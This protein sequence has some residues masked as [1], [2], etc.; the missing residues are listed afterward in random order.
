MA[1]KRGVLLTR[2]ASRRARRRVLAVRCDLAAIHTTPT[3]Y[4]RRLSPPLTPLS[5]GCNSRQERLRPPLFTVASLSPR[6]KLRTYIVR[7][8]CA[9]RVCLAVLYSIHTLSLDGVG[10]SSLSARTAQKQTITT[11]GMAE[12][13]MTLVVVPDSEQK[14]QGRGWR[15]R[16]LCRSGGSQNC[17][18]SLAHS[19]LFLATS[20]THQPAQGDS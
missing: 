14:W 2:G 16:P 12:G 4:I 18:K 5:G 17:L 13:P 3:K 10:M 8:V 1:G 7:C 6:R 11:T 20:G 15:C 19:F 9:R